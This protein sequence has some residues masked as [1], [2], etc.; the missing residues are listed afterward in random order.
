MQVLIVGGGKTGSYLA[1]K[2][3]DEHEVTLIEQRSDRATIAGAK[4]PGVRVM[5]GDAC[6]PD[7]LDRAGIA[8]T[9]LVAALTGDDEDNLV[10]SLLSKQMHAVPLTFARVNHP[11]NEWMFTRL[12]GVDFAMS[13]A[14][15]IEGMVAKEVALGDAITLLRLQQEGLVIDDLKLPPDADSVGK[16]IAEVGLPTWT[17][18]IAIVSATGEVDVPTGKT[19]LKAGDELLLVT[20]TEE[21]GALKDL[22]GVEPKRSG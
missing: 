19:V 10:V 20:K 17:R 16:S 5:H 21:E 18:V 1:Q 13:A 6:D 12:W 3:K 14:S 4:L 9:D 15:V 8:D 22:F 2:F 11:N 7:V